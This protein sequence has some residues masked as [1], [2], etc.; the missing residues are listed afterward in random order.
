MAQLDSGLFVPCRSATGI[1]K[2]FVS[3]GVFGL[4]IRFVEIG[5]SLFC[6]SAKQVVLP[7]VV[8]YFEIGVC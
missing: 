3:F 4:R 7:P 1:A 8:V 2:Q 6:T 5:D